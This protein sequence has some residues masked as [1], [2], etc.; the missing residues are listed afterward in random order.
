MKTEENNINNSAKRSGLLIILAIIVCIGLLGF[1]F[2]RY[3][4]V[5]NHKENANL[6]DFNIQVLDLDTIAPP[7]WQIELPATTRLYD[8][9]N[10]NDVVI[11]RRLMITNLSNQTVEIGAKLKDKTTTDNHNHQDYTAQSDDIFI[12]VFNY[13]VQSDFQS[14]IQSALDGSFNADTSFA[15]IKANIQSVCTENLKNWSYDLKPGESR[16][17][18]VFVW[19][20]NADVNNENS[21]GKTV[22]LKEHLELDVIQK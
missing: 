2:A 6:A 10:F 18:T 20:E 1:S 9:V 16:F 15:D 11:S 5:E 14:E 8:D 17:L 22:Y 3:I 12:L 4:S 19:R 7:D 13:D 21:F